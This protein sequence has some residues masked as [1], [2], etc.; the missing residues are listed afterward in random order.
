MRSSRRVPRYRAVPPLTAISVGRVEYI[1]DSRKE[2]A[3]IRR[4][5]LI[6]L[7]LPL[8]QPTLVGAQVKI[9]QG[10]I[11]GEIRALAFGAESAQI[12]AELARNGWVEC[13]GQ[14]LKRSDFLDLFTVMGD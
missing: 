8:A 13:A 12:K 6:V 4:L 1:N 11:V 3:M 9:V 7:L 2:H 14:S 10:A 5:S